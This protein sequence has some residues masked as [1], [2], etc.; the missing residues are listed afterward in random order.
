ML[1]LEQSLNQGRIDY[2]TFVL[3]VSELAHSTPQQVRADLDSNQPNEP[4]F[5]YIQAAI[6]PHFKLGLLSNAGDDW[7]DELIGPARAGLFDAIVLSYQVGITKP[8]RKIYTL[9]AERLAVQPEAC[10]MVDDRAEY[11]EGARLA[12]MQAVQYKT[13]AQIMRE[14]A[15]LTNP[16][17]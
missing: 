17:H 7:L 6:K 12:G 11:C 9:M 3:K 8:D 4:L 15:A 1:Q 14:L 2:P 5:D 13:V 10:V 16:E